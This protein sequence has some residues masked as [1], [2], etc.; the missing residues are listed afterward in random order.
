MTDDDCLIC[1]HTASAHGEFGCECSGGDDGQI[2]VCCCSN[3]TFGET[4]FGVFRKN[5][6]EKETA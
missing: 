3:Q 6:T 2:W 1:G 5:R 4:D